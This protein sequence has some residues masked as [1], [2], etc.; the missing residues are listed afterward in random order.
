MDSAIS[1]NIVKLKKEWDKFTF[2]PADSKAA[3]KAFDEW[4]PGEKQNIKEMKL[5]QYTNLL[6]KGDGYFTNWM[7]RKTEACGKF[8]TSS[9]SYGIYRENK[10]EESYKSAEQRGKSKEDK[11]LDLDGAEKYFKEKVRPV[12]SDLAEFKDLPLGVTPL[13][14]NYARKIAYMYNPGM[15][16][17][18]FKREV[19]EAIANFLGVDVDAS[20]YKAT[21]II[22]DELAN[23]WGLE[24]PNF[25]I[26]QKL[27]AFLWDMFGKS[28]D[29]QHKNIIF[30]GAPGTGK[31]YKIEGIKQRILIA[32]DD[33]NEVLDFAQFHPSYSYEDFIEGFKPVKSENGGISLELK[34]GRFKQFCKKAMK[35]L[36]EARERGGKLKSYY[37]V[38]DEINRAELSRVLG[39]VL[40]CLEETKRIDFDEEGKPTG[41]YLKSQYG[42]LDTEEQAVLT[43]NEEHYFGVPSNLYFVG[44]MNDIDRSIDSFDLALR[45]RFVWEKMVCDYGVIKEKLASIKDAESVEEYVKIC[46]KLNE[47]IAESWG[48]GQSYQI[49]H[50]YFCEVSKINTSALQ[51]LFDQKIKPLLNE[52]L[53]AEYAPNEIEQKLQVA[54]DVFKL[55]AKQDAN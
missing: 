12:V 10:E 22:L 42:H 34:S 54:Q 1:T 4:K 50:A 8:R 38:A 41:L 25:E 13:E 9:Y 28:F 39:E 23:K 46:E 21:K 17:P 43:I 26:T 49:G 7:E 30:Y 16:L 14:I 18:I 31:T 5:D 44:T 27:G 45:R 47:L 48:L 6:R 35:N 53:R 36:R 40:V 33:E 11:P 24:V 2:E 51:S 32:G 52:Y 3:K 20:N 55:S 29:L 19:I 37:F 15:L